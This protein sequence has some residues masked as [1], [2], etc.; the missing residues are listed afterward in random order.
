MP[1]FVEQA[2][3]VGA[4]VPHGHGAAESE[5][6]VF[7]MFLVGINSA[8]LVGLENEFRED[9]K[10]IPADGLQ[11]PAGHVERGVPQV[12]EF[13][14]FV[15]LLAR[16]FTQVE[17]VDDLGVPLGAWRQRGARDGCDRW[18]G[19]GQRREGDQH[20]CGCDHVCWGRPCRGGWES[21]IGRRQRGGWG[22]CGAG[23]DG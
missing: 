14:V 11:A 13:D 1:F 10:F 19:R 20:Y 9:E 22:L 8:G 12:G 23:V 4:V 21:G 7:T 15:A 17:D 2:R 6:A 3:A 16:P 5:A 18:R